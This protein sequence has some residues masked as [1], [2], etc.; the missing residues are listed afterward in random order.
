MIAM[1]IPEKRARIEKIEISLNLLAV[2]SIGCS[3]PTLSV[4]CGDG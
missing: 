4:F 1:A 3:A 2:S